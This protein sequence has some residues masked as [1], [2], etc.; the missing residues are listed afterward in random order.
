MAKDRHA[1]D[2]SFEEYRDQQ[3]TVAEEKAF[4][5][6][7]GLSAPD[8]EA[9][10]KTVKQEV[11]QVIAKVFRTVDAVLGVSPAVE[12]PE[13]ITLTLRQLL[14][15][16]LAPYLRRDKTEGASMLDLSTLGLHDESK[17][18]GFLHNHGINLDRPVDLQYAVR[19]FNEAAN[20]YDEYIANGNKPKMNPKLRKIGNAQDI[21]NIFKT[22]AGHGTR[23]LTP[24][25]CALLRIAMVIDFM[26]KD[27][28]I[29]ALPQVQDEL[30]STVHRHVRK[31]GNSY[32]Y[33]SG[34]PQEKPIPLIAAEARV[35]NRARVIMKLLHKA[36]NSTSE[37]VDHIGYRFVTES[38]S[39]ALR[40]IYQMFFDHSSSVLPAMNIRIGRTKQSLVDPVLLMNALKDN[41]KAQ[42]IFQ[43]LS[44]ETIN[45]QD[46]ESQPLTGTENGHSSK[47]YRAI[48]ITVDFPV[49]I[50]GNHQFFPIEIQFVDKNSRR[51]NDEL[52]P[53]ENYV[54]RQSEAASVRVLENNLLTN[55]QHRKKLV[56][57]KK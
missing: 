55:Y 17:I 26:E 42:E 56:H 48:H 20:F 31:V 38:A 5:H 2:I 35:K 57:A 29:S 50:N 10:K 53:H 30:K 14:A 39:D 9:P 18:R 52:A 15:K 19:V 28:L 45:H 13:T 34:S 32:M 27:P 33:H 11:D 25:A 54:V 12:S 21:Y 41:R 47:E 36:S 44:I 23:Q 8:E 1:P 3:N 46:V 51:G 37:V 16:E 40:L 22:S 43:Q 49:V 7:L 6:S 4:L 24:Q